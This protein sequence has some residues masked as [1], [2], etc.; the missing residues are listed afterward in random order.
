MLRNVTI[1][2]LKAQD[3]NVALCNQWSGDEQVI[4]TCDVYMQNNPYNT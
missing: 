3:E 1:A 2:I 4:C